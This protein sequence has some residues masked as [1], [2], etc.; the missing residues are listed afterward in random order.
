MAKLD[1]QSATWLKPVLQKYGK[2][3][4]RAGAPGGWNLS[5]GNKGI[6][7][8]LNSSA[9][10]Y[11][12]LARMPMIPKTAP[13][14]QP[15]MIPKPLRQTVKM[16]KLA[17]TGIINEMLFQVMLQARMDA[18]AK[19]RAEEDLEVAAA[20]QAAAQAGA[21]RARTNVKKKTLRKIRSRPRIRVHGWSRHDD[22]ALVDAPRFKR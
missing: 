3:L 10:A 15:K 1:E 22:K 20:A 9:D 14:T 19:R 5:V 12:A 8:A 18:S 13:K 4:P 11:K 21:A 6:V 17:S 7:G 16:P 2:P